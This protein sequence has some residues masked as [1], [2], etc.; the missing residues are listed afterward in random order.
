MFFYII[1]LH[2]C[3]LKKNNE[4]KNGQIKTRKPIIKNNQI[5]SITCHLRLDIHIQYHHITNIQ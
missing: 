1:Y 4:E 3:Y 2:F 5:N